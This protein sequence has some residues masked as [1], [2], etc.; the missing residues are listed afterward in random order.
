MSPVHYVYGDKETEYL[1]LDTCVSV[2]Y[3]SVNSFTQ[4]N[5]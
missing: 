3:E 1:A 5:E 4:C 2:L